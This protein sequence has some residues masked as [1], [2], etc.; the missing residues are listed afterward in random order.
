MGLF[1]PTIKLTQ[2]EEKI[3]HEVE[4]AH[5]MSIEYYEKQEYTYQAIRKLNQAIKYFYEDESF[6]E[7]RRGL[8]YVDGIHLHLKNYA[9]ISKKGYNNIIKTLNKEG[10][11]PFEMINRI[12]QYDQLEQNYLNQ[13]ADKLLKIFNETRV[14]YDDFK[15]N[16]ELMVIEYKKLYEN[17]FNFVHTREEFNDSTV[18]YHMYKSMDE[19]TQN[20][21]NHYEN[22]REHFDLDLYRIK[23]LIKYMENKKI[24]TLGSEE[25]QEA[26]QIFNVNVEN[27]KQII[28]DSA[29]R[30]NDLLTKF[31]QEKE[32][33]EK[34]LKELYFGLK[35]F[36]KDL[37][38]KNEFKRA[39]AKEA[40][41]E[42]REE[43]ISFCT[44][45]TVDNVFATFS[46]NIEK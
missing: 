39:I 28:K 6:T 30:I 34:Q 37:K 22:Q 4:R 11:D 35:S 25:K 15:N 20:I 26:L 1:N 33:P 9:K 13:D 10:I 42:L 21:Y 12:P 40:D 44:S 3:V 45:K 17:L 24:F 8:N 5:K 27:Q 23:Y 31:D 41:M 36:D 19:K 14:L 43:G 32:L 18:S 46:D 2:R 29:V 16:K 38:S 7:L